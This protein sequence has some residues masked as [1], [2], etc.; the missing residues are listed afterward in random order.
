M[1]HVDGDIS[2]YLLGALEPAERAR[3]RAHINACERCAGLGVTEVAVLT[4][5]AQDVDPVRPPDGVRRNIMVAA[6]SGKPM[7]HGR[8]LLPFRLDVT[9][10]NPAL[11]WASLG[12]AAAFVV[13]LVGGVTGWAL[14]LGDRLD[15]RDSQLNASRNTLATLVHSSNIATMDGSINAT[16][17]RAALGT[18]S[19]G[20]G[21]VL[22][23]SDLPQPGTGQA[24]HLWLFSNGA[25]VF[26]GVW[27]PDDHG[28]V[29]ASLGADL[30]SYDRMELALEPVGS[31]AP[32]GTPVVAGAL[33]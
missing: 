22:V 23:V 2:G 26:A 29:I 20:T 4:A 10:R 18:T 1:P 19:S 8:T 28:D 5:L 9:S 7:R 24:Y 27:V 21:T 13:G 15:K 14:V 17:V 32:M 6:R 30:R 3:V 12:V 31:S 33:R 16:P 11:R 25:A